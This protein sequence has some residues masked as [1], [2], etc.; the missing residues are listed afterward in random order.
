MFDTVS[1]LLLSNKLR[2][3]GIVKLLLDF[4]FSPNQYTKYQGSSSNT[5]RDVLLKIF[6]HYFIKKETTLKR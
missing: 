5:F 4:L 2:I 1:V 6:Q 3:S